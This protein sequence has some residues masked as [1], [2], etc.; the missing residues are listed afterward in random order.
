[1]AEDETIL[2]RS[3]RFKV[4]AHPNAIDIDGCGPPI[5]KITFSVK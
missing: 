5:M 3:A 1:M 2:R 4:I